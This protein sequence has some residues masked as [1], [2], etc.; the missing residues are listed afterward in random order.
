[1]REFQL[2]AV[3]TSNLRQLQLDL[4]ISNLKFQQILFS[5]YINP[6]ILGDKIRNMGKSFDMGIIHTG[7]YLYPSRKHHNHN[8]LTDWTIEECVNHIMAVIDVLLTHTKLVI[9]VEPH[10]RCIWGPPT[11][12]LFNTLTKNRFFIM[13]KEIQN[14]SEG[15]SKNVKFLAF[16]V[17][18]SRYFR[19]CPQQHIAV[20]FSRRFLTQDGVHLTAQGSDIIR[21]NL[22]NHLLRIGAKHDP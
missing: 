8:C 20:E 15:I 4:V 1:M 3:G 18:I 22:V 5:S 12:K 9:V 13:S 14:R 7:N 17:L 10:P 21:S 16:K 11:C 19:D 6:T 2:L